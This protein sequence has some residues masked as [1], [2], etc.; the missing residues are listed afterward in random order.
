MILDFSKYTLI[1]L[2]FFSFSVF[3]QEKRNIIDS[4][5]HK[6]LD[7]DWMKGASVSFE[8][9]SVKSNQVV[10]QFEAEKS[11]TPAS[12][13]KLFSTANALDK[14]GPNYQYKTDLSYSGVFENSV[15]NGDL[16]IHGSG[17]P[18]LTLQELDS[19]IRTSLPNLSEITGHI[20]VDASLYG[21]QT[22]PYKW[23]WEDLGNYYGAGVNSLN[24]DDNIYNI[25]L[26]TGNTGD[27]AEIISI[28]PKT[29]YLTVESEVLSGEKGTGDNSFI[30]SSPYSN[31]HIIRGTLPPNR[32]KFKV[33]G[34][35]TNPD[36]HAAY[37]LRDNLVKNGVDIRL[38]AIK[39]VYIKD[40]LPDS[41][42]FSS[43]KSIP[44]S[45]IID[46]TNKKSINLYAEALAKTVSIKETA[47]ILPDSIAKS[48][49][50]YVAKLGGD[51]QGIFLE[52]GSGLSPFDAFSAHHMV[53]FL[54]KIR[55]ESYFDDFENSL[56]TTGKSGTLKYFCRYNKA[57]G[58]ITGKSGSM[59]RVRSYAGY[60]QTSNDVLA[61]T[62]IVNNF[63][64]NHKTMR[65]SLEPLMEILTN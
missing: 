47:S 3:S 34:G 11:L 36:Y 5:F 12:I 55:H 31:S 43:V 13:T 48:I 40:D 63:S 57:K 21:K 54:C 9:R 41:K 29:P 51:S 56:A 52:D 37:M 50:N 62:I 8:V 65:K 19:A 18:T 61:F 38:D 17:D 25:Y 33:K 32:K 60:I 27:R 10:Y 26:N 22:T 44:I 49:I 23:V 15:L 59:R 16:I 4:E 28:S 30:F 24:I 53:S 14:L 46:K 2:F 20:I 58:K 42:S 39:V 64:C 1:T 7:H 35:I 45:L 6:L